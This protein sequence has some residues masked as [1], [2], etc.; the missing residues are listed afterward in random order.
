MS[1]LERQPNN[2]IVGR[3]QTGKLTG[4]ITDFWSRFFRTL[5]DLLDKAP[6]VVGSVTLTGVLLAV[7]DTVPVT[8]VVIQEVD[9]GSYEVSYYMRVE[10]VAGVTGD[11]TLTISW[12]D[13]GVTLSHSSALMNGNTVGTHKE[14]TFQIQ[15]D[16]GGPITYSTVYN[17]NPANAMHHSI[18]I[19]VQSVPDAT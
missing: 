16:S 15:V 9:A 3:D 17:S 13:G 1:K 19:R 2:E 18:V 10:Q 6:K 8:P 14:E 5:S 7:R 12:P 11:V 4:I